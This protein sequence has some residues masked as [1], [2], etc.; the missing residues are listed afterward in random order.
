[1][2]RTAEAATAALGNAAFYAAYT[3][4]RALTRAD[5]VALVP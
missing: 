3:S 1:V 4:G 5:A 2:A